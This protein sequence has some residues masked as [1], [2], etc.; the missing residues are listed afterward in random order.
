[1]LLVSIQY[2][3]GWRVENSSTHALTEPTPFFYPVD[4][5]NERYEELREF[6]SW[7]YFGPKFPKKE[8]LSL[9]RER[10]LENIRKPYSFFAHMGG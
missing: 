7:S 6:P 4:R 1:M 2:G 3:Q 8:I 10:L 9:Q 5:F